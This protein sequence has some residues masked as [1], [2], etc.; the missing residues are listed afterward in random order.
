MKNICNIVSG[1]V[2]VITSLAIL[3]LTILELKD[4]IQKNRMKKEH[5]ASQNKPNEQ[6]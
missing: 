2:A 5:V 4:I 6:V 1:P 3:T